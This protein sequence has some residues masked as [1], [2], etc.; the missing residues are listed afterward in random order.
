DDGV[1]HVPLVLDTI[2]GAERITGEIDRGQVGGGVGDRTIGGGPVVGG[3]DRGGLDAHLVIQAQVAQAPAGGG[4]FDVEEPGQVLLVGVIDRL[5]QTA[6]DAIV[7]VVGP[8]ARGFAIGTC[9]LANGCP[10]GEQ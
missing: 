10:C 5:F 8:L 2:D 9:A 3:V 6:V 1:G 4:S 7:G